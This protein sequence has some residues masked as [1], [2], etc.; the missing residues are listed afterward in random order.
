M[1][2]VQA[3]LNSVGK[4]YPVGW[5]DSLMFQLFH[6]NTEHEHRVYRPTKAS[7]SIFNTYIRVIEL[8]CCGKNLTQHLHLMEFSYAATMV[9]L[10]YRLA[11]FDMQ[12][13][14]C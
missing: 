14:N 5:P 2:N 8:V 3:V 11:K 10:A 6:N 12:Y 13:L 9:P 1:F 7:I 4:G